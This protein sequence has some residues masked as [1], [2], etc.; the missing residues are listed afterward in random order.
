MEAPLWDNFLVREPRTRPFRLTARM[1]DRD[2]KLMH[3]ARKGDPDAFQALVQ[4]HLSSVRRFAYSF[5][6][7]WS[8]ADDLAQEALLKAFRA[9]GDFEGRAALSTWLYTV[10]RSVC[11][12]HHRSAYQR[13][14]ALHEPPDD[15]VEDARPHADELLERRDE[16]AELWDAI[17]ELDPTF[18][19]P[20]VLFDIEGCSYEDVARIEQVPI[21]TVRSRLSRARKRLRA[22]LDQSSDP[23]RPARHRGSDPG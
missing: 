1:S 14:R 12:D 13:R 8:D 10:V 21:G 23:A 22:A 4:P 2:A 19:I 6:R 20:I 5:A 15:N 18:R 11:Q 3:R 17:R 7:D 16:A 9:F